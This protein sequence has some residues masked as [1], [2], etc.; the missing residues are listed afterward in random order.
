MMSALARAGCLVV[1][2]PDAPAAKEG[3]WVEVIPLD[4]VRGA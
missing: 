3:D 2:P 4:S 1:R